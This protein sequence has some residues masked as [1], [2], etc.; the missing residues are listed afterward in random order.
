MVLF[1]EGILHKCQG[2]PLISGRAGLFGK[3]LLKLLS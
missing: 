1:R 2:E 3:A